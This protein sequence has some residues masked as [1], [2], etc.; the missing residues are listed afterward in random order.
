MWVVRDGFDELPLSPLQDVN[1][2]IQWAVDARGDVYLA[3]QAYATGSS[4]A[5][6]L[7]RVS[8][9]GR[10][11]WTQRIK[12]E[13]YSLTVDAA[14]TVYQ[15]RKLSGVGVLDKRSADGRWLW[16]NEVEAMALQLGRDGALY[17]AAWGERLRKFDDE[18]NVLW[19]WQGPGQRGVSGFGADASGTVFVRTGVDPSA[20]LPSGA[21][22][23]SAPQDGLLFTL[24]QSGAELSQRRYSTGVYEP[25]SPVAVVYLETGPINFV[26]TSAGQLLS[27]PLTGT[28]TGLFDPPG[29]AVW[30]WDARDLKPSAWDLA[31]DRTRGLSGALSAGRCGYCASSRQALYAFDAD[32]KQSKTLLLHEYSASAWAADNED[33]IYALVRNQETVA[34]RRYH[35]E[36]GWS[37]AAP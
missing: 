32:G 19:T 18:G 21:K 10:T 28:G 13:P 14:G 8:A 29:D 26:V 4:P 36:S 25:T 1:R 17:G 6:D 9:D 30:H 35:G 5:F 34:I 37:D 2:S 24:D 12:G 33:N 7:S 27:A 16:S 22:G 15:S 20:Q 11:N 23:Q 3:S 31:W